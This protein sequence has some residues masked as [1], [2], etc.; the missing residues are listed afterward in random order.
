MRSMNAV[1]LDWRPKRTAHVRVATAIIIFVL[2]VCFATPN[3][4]GQSKISS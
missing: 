4:I 1:F 3:V 2:H